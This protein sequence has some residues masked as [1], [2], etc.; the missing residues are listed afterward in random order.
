MF[1]QKLFKYLKIGLYERIYSN[2][3]SFEEWKRNEVLSEGTLRAEKEKRE[4]HYYFVEPE[5]DKGAFKNCPFCGKDFELEETPNFCP[6]CK[7][8]LK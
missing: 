5:V 1:C 4:K 8:P 2:F 3:E 6:Y 7:E